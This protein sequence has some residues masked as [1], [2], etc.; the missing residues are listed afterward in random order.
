[1]NKNAYTTAMQKINIS[2]NFE[3]DTI[4]LL[5]DEKT[6]I[7]EDKETIITMKFNKYSYRRKYAKAA[8]IVFCI[9]LVIHLFP[10]LL[11]EL[12]PI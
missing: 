7:N 4:K 5:L 10:S 8:G 6:K 1:M 3:E 9:L 12:E 11:P 2:E